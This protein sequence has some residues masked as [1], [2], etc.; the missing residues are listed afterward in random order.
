[1]EYFIHS[2]RSIFRFLYHQFL[3]YKYGIVL[4]LFI[5][6]FLSIGVY[7]LLKDQKRIVEFL[8]PTKAK[9][10]VALFLLA[11][12]PVWQVYYQYVSVM[13]H[14]GG[15]IEVDDYTLSGFSVL[16]S[17]LF[18]SSAETIYLTY[19]LQ[20]AIIYL[21]SCFFVFYYKKWKS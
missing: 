20:V 3:A 6:Y 9:V 12:V 8:R 1:M 16:L 13:S 5:S 11:V 15:Y 10:F 19:P 18:L 2:E 14:C 4:T 17:M 7:H 21:F